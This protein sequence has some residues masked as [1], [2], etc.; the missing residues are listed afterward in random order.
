MFIIYIKENEDQGEGEGGEGQCVCCA[1]NGA[2]GDSLAASLENVR[3]L[4]FI[5]DVEILNG[6][7]DLFGEV[8]H[9]KERGEKIGDINGRFFH[10]PR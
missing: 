1:W 3:R 4:F 5:K 2:Q 7:G 10:Q 9:V 8:A 6:E